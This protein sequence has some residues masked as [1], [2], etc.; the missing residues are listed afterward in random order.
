[1][2]QFYADPLDLPFIKLPLLHVSETRDENLVRPIWNGI[3][4]EGIAQLFI[5]FGSRANFLNQLWR[6][7]H[8]KSLLI[9]LLPKSS[10]SD[11]ATTPQNS[12]SLS[13][14]PGFLKPRISC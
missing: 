7:L 12:H 4:E 3:F 8:Q 9:V 5:W 14:S 13:V 6:M 1:M 11:N 10:S 2:W